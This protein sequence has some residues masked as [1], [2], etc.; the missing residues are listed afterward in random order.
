MKGEKSAILGTL[1]GLLMAASG[2]P[3]FDACGLC[4]TYRLYYG[5]LAV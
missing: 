4:F 3:S 5:A 1:N 2:L